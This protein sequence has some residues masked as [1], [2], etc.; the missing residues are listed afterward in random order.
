MAEG[1]IEIAALIVGIL[2]RLALPLLLTLILAWLLGRLD[3]RWQAEAE[4]EA[5]Q[6]PARQTAVARPPCWEIRH[7][8]PDR[9]QTCPAYGRTDRA[10]WDIFSRHGQLRKQCLACDVWRADQALEALAL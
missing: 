2:L 7:C 5:A 10:C 3:A 6:A 8:A 1:W 9:R 4:A